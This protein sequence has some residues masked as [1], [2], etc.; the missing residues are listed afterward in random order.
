[1]RITT[2]R[3]LRYSS[4]TAR[5][6]LGLARVVRRFVWPRHAN[7]ML[8]TTPLDPCACEMSAQGGNKRRAGLDALLLRHVFRPRPLLLRD[9]LQQTLL[10]PPHLL[11]RRAR[12]LPHLLLL[13]LGL[14]EHGAIQKRV[15]EYSSRYG[16][17]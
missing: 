7:S 17:R 9:A 10:A 1:M 4:H 12:V 2:P 11:H 16:M 14:R 15:L 6:G 8:S 13:L 5:S 3:N